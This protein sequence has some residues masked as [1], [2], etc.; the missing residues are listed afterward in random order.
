MKAA[1]GRIEGYRRGFEVA[2]AEYFAGLVA[3]GVEGPGGSRYPRECV[4]LLRDLSLRGGKRL[5]VALV[6]EAARLVTEEDVAGLAEAALSVELMQTYG[7]VHDDIIDDS[8]VRRGGPSTYYAYRERFPGQERK[9]LGLAVLAG[10]LAWTLALRVLAEG[11]ADPEVRMAMLQVQLRAGQDA[12]VGQLTDLERDTHPLP[13]RALLDAVTEFKSTRY[14]ILAP[15]RFGLLAAGED[16]DRY[17]ERLRR[18]AS[19]VGRY[20][21]MRDDYLD[22]FADQAALGKSAGADLRAGRRTYVVCAILE[23]ATAAEQAEVEA[24]LADPHGTAET[25]ARVREIAQR[26]GVDARLRA[27]MRRIAEAASAEAGTWRGQWRGQWREEAVGFFEL[28]PLWSVDR[29]R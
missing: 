9:A 29:T 19:L 17:D 8:S 1:V 16:L 11:K 10:D 3:A 13:S 27:E 23:A 6:Y 22:L 26:H 20:E 28:L 18:Y 15:L 4:E 2:F 14:S 7:L 24:A 5:R 25:I 12:V 21:Q